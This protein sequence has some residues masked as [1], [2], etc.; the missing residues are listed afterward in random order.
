M[1]SERQALVELNVPS[2]GHYCKY[3]VGMAKDGRKVIC[4]KPLEYH[5]DIVR[6]FENRNNELGELQNLRGGFVKFQDGVYLFSG[7]S[8]SYGTADHGKVSSL[9]NGN[10]LSKKFKIASVKLKD[11]LKSDL[12]DLQMCYA[13]RES[14]K[15]TVTGTV[16]LF[17]YAS[18]WAISAYNGFMGAP[19]AAN[20]SVTHLQLGLAGLVGVAA[21]A[22]NIL[23]S[24]KGIDG[25]L[26][27][28]WLAVIG[29]GMIA[30][31]AYGLG[32]G[33]RALIDRL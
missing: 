18:I 8:G 24:H 29:T 14:L 7:S 17:G 31:V 9:V 1:N 20:D 26:V 30:G 28:G 13:T 21:A 12:L 6:D 3:I 32:V 23:N 19:L 25:P 10:S 33:A 27:E 5:R 2:E 4:A 22:D 15:R 16:G 11:E